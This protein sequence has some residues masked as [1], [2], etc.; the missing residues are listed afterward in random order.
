[1][2][3]HDNAEVISTQ[4]HQSRTTSECF[5]KNDMMGIC[6]VLYGLRELLYRKNDRWGSHTFEKFIEPICMGG[7]PTT[8]GELGIRFDDDVVVFVDEKTQYP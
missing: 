7:I 1:M 2:S 4:I 5:Q 8:L 3:R 6:L